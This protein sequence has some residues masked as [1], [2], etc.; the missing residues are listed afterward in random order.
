MTLL[1]TD[2]PGFLKDKKTGVLH[3]DNVGQLVSIQ[4]QR[5]KNA[6]YIKLVKRV[7]ALEKEFKKLIEA[8][9]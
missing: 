6:D 8:L 9:K 7:E 4:A 5:K 1:K 3:N 2:H